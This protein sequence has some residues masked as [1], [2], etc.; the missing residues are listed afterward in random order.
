MKMVNN[1]PVNNLPALQKSYEA[2]NDQQ[3][4]LFVHQNYYYQDRNIPARAVY[5]YSTDKNFG[6]NL[7][8]FF[9]YQYEETV[10]LENQRYYRQW[11]NDY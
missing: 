9:L 8:Q 4:Y 11:K 2:A 1:F 5:P 3:I 10:S 7:I 6:L